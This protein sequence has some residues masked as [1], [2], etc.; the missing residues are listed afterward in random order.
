[1]QADTPLATARPTT[2]VAE[3]HPYAGASWWLD[4]R[5]AIRVVLAEHY[6]CD[7]GG[8]ELGEPR[9]PARLRLRLRAAAPGLGAVADRVRSAFRQDGACAVLVPSL[10]T[11]AGDLDQRRKALFA[12]SALLGDPMA[13][14]PD[15]TVVWDVRNRNLGKVRP[16]ASDS[17]RRAGYHTDA[18]YLPVP[19]RYFLLYAARAARCGGGISLI[20]DGRIVLHEL[21]R[22]EQGR[23]AIEVLRQPVPRRVSRNLERYSDLRADGFLHVP[24]LAD[25]PVWRWSAGRTKSVLDTHPELSAPGLPEAIDLAHREIK[26]GPG[27]FRVRL[28]TDSLLLIDNHVALHARTAFTD[29]ERTLFRIRFHEAEDCA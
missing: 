15:E 14:H 5:A 2:C 1:M 13:N 23:A 21:A 27:E 17:D 24:M 18:G 10:G 6:G 9:D 22:S 11:A 8:L 16:K 4:E 12:L 26:H 28:D 25:G 29:P 3:V 19:P 20:K 7:L